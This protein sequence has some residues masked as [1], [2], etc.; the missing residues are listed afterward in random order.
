[1]MSPDKGDRSCGGLDTFNDIFH[2][3][4]RHRLC[5]ALL[6]QLAH[7]C[8]VLVAIR[9]DPP[10]T[11]ISSFPAPALASVPLPSSTS[12]PRCRRRCTPCLLF[13]FFLWVAPSSWINQHRFK[14]KQVLV[15][16]LSKSYAECWI[17]FQTGSKPDT[18]LSYVFVIFV[19]YFFW[20]GGREEKKSR[21]AVCTGYWILV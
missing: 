5:P 8:Y 20:F 18:I 14:M 16:W 21:C 3:S 6:I 10:S 19:L 12:Q 1:M 2:W 9:S 11:N 17:C 13:L 4:Y 15:M 7:P